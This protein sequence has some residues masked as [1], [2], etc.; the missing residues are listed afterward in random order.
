M[1]WRGR[2]TFERFVMVVVW[3]FWG[4]LFFVLFSSVAQAQKNEFVKDP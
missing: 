3:F 2:L 4:L 1:M